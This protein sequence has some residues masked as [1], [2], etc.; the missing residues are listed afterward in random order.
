MTC[1]DGGARPLGPKAQHPMLPIGVGYLRPISLGVL[2]DLLIFHRL[3]SSIVIKARLRSDAR[4]E[5]RA[6]LTLEL[7]RVTT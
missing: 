2:P 5:S 6:G 1:R 4:T 3:H 7:D